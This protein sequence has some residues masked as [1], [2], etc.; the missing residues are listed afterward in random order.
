MRCAALTI[1]AILWA[2]F[3]MLGVFHRLRKH[4]GQRVSD[5]NKSNHGEGL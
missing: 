5:G 1:L 4:D 3:V 2:G